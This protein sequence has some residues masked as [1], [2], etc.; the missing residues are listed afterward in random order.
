M[1]NR[2]VQLRMQRKENLLSA[3]LSETIVEFL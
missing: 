2:N 3:D 1:V